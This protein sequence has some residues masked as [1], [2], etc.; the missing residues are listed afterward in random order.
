MPNKFAHTLHT[1]KKFYVLTGD[2]KE[3]WKKYVGKITNKNIVH[4]VGIEY[5]TLT[6]PRGIR[7]VKLGGYT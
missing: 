1:L 4:R 6:S 5:Y 7:T 2:G 3:L